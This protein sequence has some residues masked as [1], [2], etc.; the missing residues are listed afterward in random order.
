MKKVLI[1]GVSGFLGEML[2]QT[3]PI[4]TA[5][6]GIY[7]INSITAKNINLISLD[8]RDF[9]SLERFIQQ[10]KPDAI[11]HT[12]ALSKPNTCQQQPEL[13]FTLNV[14]VSEYLA[15]LAARYQIPLVFT[16]TDLVFD[17]KNAPYKEEDSLHPICVYGEHKALAEKNILSIHPQSIV[18][19]LPL[20]YGF[21]SRIPNFFT[22]WQIRL[23]AGQSITAFSNEYR[24]AAYGLDVAKGIWLLL[25]QQQ[26]GIWHLGGKE[27]MSRLEFALQ[28]ASYLGCSKA[29]VNAVQQK[30]VHMPAPRPEDVSLDSSKAFALG[31]SPI[32][33]RDFFEQLIT[34]T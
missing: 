33:L 29:L 17:G 9:P 21:S 18:A 34:F 13:S 31:Y 25:Q 2:L 23:K 14:H 4:E 24:T 16:S 3:A 20:M 22:D 27:R 11:I 12:A 7:H 32:F 10:I 28:M 19:R 8:L 6:S 15:T 1:T 30:E 5:L 26:S